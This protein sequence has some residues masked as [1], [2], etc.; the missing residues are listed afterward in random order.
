M[1]LRLY[2]GTE[3]LFQFKL[4]STRAKRLRILAM[5]RLRDIGGWEHSY[6]IWSLTPVEYIRLTKSHTGATIL[7]RIVSD[8]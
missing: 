4:F 2:L 6:A 5:I 8:G 3:N 7:R 1:V